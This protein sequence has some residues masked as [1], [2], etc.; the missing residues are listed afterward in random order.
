VIDYVGPETLQVAC[1]P[2][3]VVGDEGGFCAP[4]IR[5]DVSDEEG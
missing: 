3:D 1:E 5:C 2:A 4:E